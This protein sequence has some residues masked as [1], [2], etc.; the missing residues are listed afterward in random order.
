MNKYK[1]LKCLWCGKTFE[2]PPVVMG[3]DGV[4]FSVCSEK[5]RDL[6]LK[7]CLFVD[8]FKI[9]VSLGIFLPLIFYVITTSLIPFGIEVLTIP[10]ERFVFRFFIALT[11][12]SVSFLYRMQDIKDTEISFPFP[13]H[14]LFLLGIRSILWIFRIMGI[15]WIAGSVCFLVKNTG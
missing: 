7:F 6:V 12:V 1:H 13:V 10:W 3:I 9:P 2:K 8:K 14:N 4:S 5:H 15:W 11:V